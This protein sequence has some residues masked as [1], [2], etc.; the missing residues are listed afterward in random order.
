VL[1][2]RLYDVGVCA[3]ADV[4]LR[5][6]ARPILGLLVKRTRET[7]FLGV[8]TPE[9]TV[10]HLDK[11]VSPEVIRYDA[12]LG[13]KRPA[14]C[15]AMGKAL[16]AALP[17]PRLQAYL[18]GRK[19][20]RFTPATLTTP[21]AL[22]RELDRVRETGVATSVDERVPGASAIGAA[23]HAPSGRAVAAVIVAGPSVRLVPRCAALAASVKDAADRISRAL[24]DGRSDGSP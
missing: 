9:F 3:R 11:V 4:R 13:Q 10:L 8:L 24:R 14:H 1:G 20:E 15:T 16:L 23:V 21:E 6:V 19:L 5:A 17:A 2:A 7:A 18:R 12:E 22:V